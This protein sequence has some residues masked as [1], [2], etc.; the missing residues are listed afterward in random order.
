MKLT[1]ISVKRSVTFSMIYIVAIGFGIFSLLR[2][3]L[4]MYPEI[5]FPRMG[6]IVTYEGSSPQDIEEMVT[7]VVEEAVASVEG[8]K[9]IDSTSK[10]GASVTFVEFDWG[11]DMDQAET[12]VRRALDLFSDQL[13]QGAK[14][15]IVFVFDPAMQPILFIAISGP[16]NQAKLREISEH[17]IEPL[18]ERIEGVASAE[19]IGGLEREI[20]VLFD[21]EKLGIF[22]ISPLQI[23][24]ALGKENIKMP[25]GNIVEGDRRL[26]IFTEGEFKS[27]EEI[28][29]VVITYRNGIPIRIRDVAQVLD[30]FHETTRIVRANYKPA[31]ILLVRKQSGANT[32]QVIEKVRK[33]FPYILSTLP[34][35]VELK[36]IF[37]QADY[38]EKSLGNLG[39]NAILAVVITFLVLLFFLQSIKASLIVSTAIPISII[40]TFGVMDQIG[41]TLNIISMAGLALAVGML[42]D[43]AIVVLENIYRTYQVE[44][45]D[46]ITASIKGCNEVGLAIIA[47]TLTTVAVFFPVVFVPGIAGAMFRDMALTICFSLSVSLI[48]AL[49]FIPLLTS[50]FLGKKERGKLRLAHKIVFTVI[51]FPWLLLFIYRILRPIRTFL[52]FVSQK[53]VEKITLL[54]KSGLNVT[55]K[56]PL[57]TLIIAFLLLGVSIIILVKAP[58]NFFPREDDSLLLFKM[59]GAI[60][61]NIMKMDKYFRTAEL[62]IKEEVPEAEIVSSD[63][64]TG[65]GFGALFL[66]GE[67]SGIFRIRLK[68]INQRRRKEDEIEKVLREKIGKIPGIEF[69]AFTPFSFTGEYDIAINIFGYDLGMARKIGK[70]LTE[71]LKGIDGVGDI[72]FTLEKEVPLFRIYPDKDKLREVG[73]GMFILNS[74]IS[75]I[76]Q[77][78]VASLYREGGY[79]YKIIVRA[80]IDYRRNRVAIERMPILLPTGEPVPLRTVAQIKEELSPIAITRRDQRRMVTLNIVSTTKDLGGLTKKIERV[81]EE[82]KKELYKDTLGRTFTFHIGGTAEDL[83][84][85]FFYL[86]IALIVAVLLVYMVMASQFES[87]LEPFIVF[88]TLLFLPIGVGFTILVTGIPI[89]VTALIGIILLVGIAVNNS[90]VLVDAA[91]RIKERGLSSEEAI[92][93]AAV[94][95]LRPILMTASTTVIAMVP[96]ALEIGEGA[97][98]WSPMA[99]VVIGG[100]I[101]TTLATLFIIPIYYKLILRLVELLKR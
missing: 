9:R 84:E 55:M 92:K 94:I 17:H 24:E 58:T 12:N 41:I 43:N 90:I 6:V 22:K 77:G 7:R 71:R 82:Y 68:P 85:S 51:V 70:E 45:C 42:V 78:K 46:I 44:G 56:H 53:C 3:K 98:S 4:D 83:K 57:K 59:K 21:T 8:V 31:V 14:K 89:S 74:T 40:L 81:V 80:P 63:F 95:R 38:I 99:R 87:L 30:T 69:T 27:V 50:K 36:V 61:T 25:S 62:I 47:S 15:P 5:T 33:E 35:G 52:V 20:H 60:G 39:S 79:E 96:L 29:D 11:T 100:L 65:E 26:S 49:S 64:G 86:G 54:Y 66:E 37:D 2:L 18:F 23:V 48:V 34:Q 91:N 75:T 10:Y 101:S 16:Y 19:T 88:F 73:L 93:E 32:V 97:E 28:K 72:E 76:F 13:P 67:H 1:E